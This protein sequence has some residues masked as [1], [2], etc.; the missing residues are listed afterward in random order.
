MSA[1]NHGIAERLCSISRL[2]NNAVL[3]TGFDTSEAGFAVLPMLV[4][5]AQ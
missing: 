3:A 4:Y 1:I 5:P 2:N